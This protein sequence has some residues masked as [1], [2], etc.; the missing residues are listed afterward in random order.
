MEK[1]VKARLNWVR[2]YEELG[3]AG[4]VCR[5][6]GIT[7][8]TLRKWLR[9]YKDSGIAGL[10][11]LSRK[12]YHSP[13]KKLTPQN[14]AWIIELRNYRNLGARRIHSELIR[15]HNCYLSLATI[16]KVLSSSKVTPVKKLKRKKQ[17]IRYER[18]IPGDRV[19]ADTCKIAPGIY[20]YTAVDD[21]SRWR[22][23][24][25]YTRANAKNTLDFIDAIIEEFPFP[26]Q[27]LQTDRGREFFAEK[28]QRKLMMFSIKFRPNKPASP[29]LNGKVERSQRTDLEE[30]YAL[31]DLSDFDALQDELAQWQFFYNWH[32][33]HG[34][35]KGRSPNAIVH[36][37]SDKTPLWQEVHDN[38]QIKNEHIQNPVYRQEM[39]LRKLKLSL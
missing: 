7:R 14:T 4:L 6:C 8:P 30:F 33:P 3:D 1:Q 36:V 15:Q 9:R 11:D 2:L 39:A 28:V 19:Q 18:P 34:A 29:H 38:Y 22:V 24:R 10:S 20:Q 13:N 5:R 27:R 26:V 32:R 37:L 25:L 16:H 17:Y 31:A 23:L 12:P 21:C 35:L